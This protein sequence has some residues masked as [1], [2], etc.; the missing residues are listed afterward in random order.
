MDLRLDI[1]DNARSI[2]AFIVGLVVIGLIIVPLAGFFIAEE[3]II[4]IENN[5]QPEVQTLEDALLLEGRVVQYIYIKLFVTFFGGEETVIERLHSVKEIFYWW[6]IA[7]F[8]I[9]LL[10]IGSAIFAG[11]RDNH[12]IF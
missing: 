8:V 12:R 7:Y 6:I 10:I 4:I 1:P 3:A 11:T 5:E 9:V 2:I